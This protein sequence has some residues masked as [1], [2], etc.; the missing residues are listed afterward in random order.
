MTEKE[1]NPK[2]TT[3]RKP[4]ATKTVAR[5][6]DADIL[7]QNQKQLPALVDT[8]G[9]QIA[10]TIDNIGTIGSVTGTKIAAL[11]NDILSKVSASDT[12]SEFG[13]SVHKIL[14]LTRS[15]DIEALAED[16]SFLGKFK[17][18]F[19]N[20][21]NKVTDQYKTSKDQIDEILETMETG[22]ARQVGERTWLEKSYEESKKYLTELRTSLENLE[23][24]TES[25][26]GILEGMKKDKEIDIFV[27]QD[28]KELVEALERQVDT[29][30][31]LITMTQ[32][33]IPQIAAMK[34]V[35]T[36]SIAKFKDIKTIMIP[37]WVNTL[38][39]N[40]ISDRQ[41][42][43]NELTE[44]FS[45]ETNRMLLVGSKLV[46]DNMVSA[47]KAQG[48]G[49]VD[50]ETLRIAQR[51][52][53]DSMQQVIKIE[54]QLHADRNKAAIAMQNMSNE[55]ENTLRNIADKSNK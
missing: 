8:K 3:T 18:L 21:K 24:V 51:N 34:K 40:L 49:I 54:D 35:N 25:Q 38:S 22:I 12:S 28:Q 14:S 43:D 50:V 1:I 17:S 15:V 26:V 16:T 52:L 9:T 2:K 20:A 36:N 11:S 23:E 47:A 19:V 33:N 13:E 37:S 5:T 6:F 55:L 10:L 32:L 45:N 31:R 39:H 7:D 44:V 30:R 41:R 46:G 53:V 29:V 4:R 48:R 42:K 27:L